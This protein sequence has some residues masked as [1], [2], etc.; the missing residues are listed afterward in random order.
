M[1]GGAENPHRVIVSLW[2]LFF[3][4]YTPVLA[5]LGPSDVLLLV[6]ARSHTSRY[7][8]KMYREYYPEIEDWQVLELDGL[9][10]C[11]G[12]EATAADEIITR[13]QYNT[14]IADP[15]RSY[16]SV[17]G[18]E[19]TVT[20]I[21]TTAGLPYR[22][23]DCTYPD[24]IYPAGSNYNRVSQS[25]SM[26]TAASVESELTCLW[27]SDYGPNP[28]GLPNRM[29][30]P[31]H[32]Y[33]AS[34]IGLFERVAPGIK[35]FQWNHAVTVTGTAPRMEGQ[36][37]YVWPPNY[38]TVNRSFHAGDIYLTCRLDGPKRQGQTAVFAVR[39]MLERARRASSPEFGINPSVTAAV[40]D[41]APTKSEDQNRVF[42]LDGSMNFYWYEPGTV[43]PPDA[44]TILNMDDYV[45]AFKILSGG[46][47]VGEHQISRGFMDTGYGLTALLDRRA[48][49]RTTQQDLEA[50]E[51][52]VFFS[53]YGRNGDEGDTGNY[54]LKDGQPLLM[55]SNGAV[56]TSIES[57]NAVT[58]FSDVATAPVSQ[59]K[60]VDFLEAGG[61]GAI[62]HAF[63]PLSSAAIDTTFLAYNLL[64]DGDG[65]GFADLT[66]VEAAFTG[67]PFLSWSEVVLGDPLM[68]IAYGAG[69]TESW[70]P[71]PGD[72]DRNNRVNSWDIYLIKYYLNGSLR[73]GASQES[74][75]KYND[76]CDI[77]NDL[78]VNSWDLYLV[79]MYFGSIR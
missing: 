30:N 28:F 74:R 4:F 6:N 51:Q 59:C 36:M 78:V 5:D 11:S 21:I 65:D 29:V 57:F 19:T 63:E 48:G 44:R 16:L 77:N 42:N 64:A 72:V 26:V 56:F 40:F 41:D 17:L 58:L 25:C 62:G 9:P 8:A 61:T 13:D 67:I 7:I 34:S 20:V 60:I 52:V 71:L 33:R 46:A 53:C 47:S 79:K 66:F 54:W 31:Y 14:L 49:M 69:E 27:T 39:K 1:R 70:K 22:I 38:G 45:E 35:T 10:D 68:R 55:L 73:D 2:V 32:G 3:F 75:E 18:I 15:L 24:V 43:Q 12:P 37:L 23:E 50:G 76:L